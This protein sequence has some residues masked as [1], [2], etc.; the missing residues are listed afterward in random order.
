M[1][2]L[3]ASR[4]CLGILGFAL[5]CSVACGDSTGLP[6]ASVPNL[7]DTTTLFALRGT[8]IPSP[9]AYDVVFQRERRTDRGEPFDF[10]FDIDS[11]GVAVILP[12]T[13]LGITTEAGVQVVEGPFDE[14][15]TAP[16]DG[17]VSDSAT[18]IT[19][20]TVFVA[21]S[22][23]TTEL[24]SIFIGSLPRYGKF[25]ILALDMNERTVTFEALVN[26]N[27][28]FRDLEPGLPTS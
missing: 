9:S 2:R 25:R 14:I 26:V 1:V 22:R 4:V 3:S 20:E 17:F 5:L 27:C 16:T 19:V 12:S 24:C 23:A 13:V 8:S 21:R 7:I 15:V 28:G 10:A 18:S 6:P 11:T